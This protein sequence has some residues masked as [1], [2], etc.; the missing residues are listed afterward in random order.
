MATEPLDLVSVD[1]GR[2]YFNRFRQIQNNSFLRCWLP[3]IDDR[4]ADFKRK[5]N[6]SQCK[7]FGRVLEGNVRFRQTR[8]PLFD[9]LRATCS[10]GDDIWF[11][12]ANTI[13]RCSGEVEL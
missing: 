1:I 6:L 10:D 11:V 3:D 7:A 9:Q 8:Y 12:Q 5:I 13:R 2:G 4:F